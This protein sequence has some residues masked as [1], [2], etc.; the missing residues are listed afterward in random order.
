MLEEFSPESA[1]CVMLR[2]RVR[3]EERAFTRFNIRSDEAAWKVPSILRTDI[4]AP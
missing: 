2:D 3:S 4:E 1:I